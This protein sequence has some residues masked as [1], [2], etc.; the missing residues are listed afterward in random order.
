[1]ESVQPVVSGLVTAAAERLFLLSIK[2][3]VTVHG[4]TG[5]KEK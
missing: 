1:M 4:F 5:L 3:A 2:I